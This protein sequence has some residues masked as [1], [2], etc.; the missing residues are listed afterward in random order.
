MARVF[1]GI[2]TRNRPIYVQEAIR[3]VLSQTHSDLRVVVSDNASEEPAAASLDHF[4]R[5]LRDPRLCLHRQM[6]DIKEYGQGRFLL[7]QCREDYFL[8]LHDDDRIE[9]G[10]LEAAV[11]RLQEH[12]DVA[13]FVANPYIF[14]SRGAVSPK[15]TQEYLCAHGRTRYPD[16]PIPILGPLLRYGFVPISGTVFRSAALRGSGFV[17]QDCHGNY[18]FELNV[19]LRL[20]ERKESAYFTRQQLLGFRIHDGALRN[21]MRLRFNE[22]VVSTMLKLLER[23]RF[24]GR[25]ERLR[26]KMVSYSSRNYAAIHLARGEMKRCYAYLL[27]ALRLNPLSYRNW[28]YSF[29]ALLL[30]FLLRAWFRAKVTPLRPL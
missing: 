2:P 25:N 28:T 7:G 8:L 6:S 26:R 5:E 16:G 27:R 30:P 21:T 12:P 4:V 17:D 3:S 29:G 13:C 20:G 14:D 24:T 23:R 18:P 10:Y 9:P 22:H 19:F 1:V 15:L 11:R